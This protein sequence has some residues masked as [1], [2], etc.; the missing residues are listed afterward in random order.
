MDE[1][2][3]MEQELIRMEMELNDYYC[4]AGKTI[5]EKAEQEE[6]KINNLVE[7]IIETRRKLVNAKDEKF[8]PECEEHTDQGSNYCKRCG[9][10][11]QNK[12]KDEEV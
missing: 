11:Y 4:E 2:N 1:I 9:Y 5:L 8:C 3:R 6:R 12:V 7:C 10:N